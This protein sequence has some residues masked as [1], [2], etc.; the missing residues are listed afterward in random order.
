VNNQ[1]SLALASYVNNE[2]VDDPEPILDKFLD[3]R[4]GDI[5]A[6]P[7]VEDLEEDGTSR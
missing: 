3:G 4:E 1:P 2:F 6:P 7:Q 5:D